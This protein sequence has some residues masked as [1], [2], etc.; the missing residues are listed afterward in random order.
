MRG[1]CHRPGTVAP[2]LQ[3]VSAGSG[4]IPGRGGG[5]FKGRGG[6]YRAV[7]PLPLA[8]QVPSLSP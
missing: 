1:G 5:L 8:L 2:F 3:A 4:P 7:P 6:S